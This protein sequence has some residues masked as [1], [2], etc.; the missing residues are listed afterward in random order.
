MSKPFKKDGHTH[1]EYC[2]HG[3][4]QDVEELIQKAIQ[5]DFSDYSITEHAPLP[6]EI[7]TTQAAGNPE[8]WTTAAMA[9]N[10]VEHYFK[11]MQLLKK[12]Y[13]SDIQLHIG[14]ELDYFD[15]AQDWTTDFLNEYGPLTDDGVLSVHFLP[16]NGGLWGIDYSFE[17]Y[18]RGVVDSLGSFQAAQ[19]LYYQKVLAS[20]QADLGPYKP[21]RLGH[22][23]LCQK[24][25]ALFPE[26]TNLSLE[27][28]QLIQELYLNIMQQ[29]Y[30][31][32]LNTA[33][34]DKAAYG[35]SYPGPGLIKQ[36]LA[37]RIP[38]VYGSDAHSF[39]EVGRYYDKVAEVLM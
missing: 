12:K 20:L 15:A 1:T 3:N 28:L 39:Q 5:L 25:E 26:E 23:T 16:G 4:V 21:K 37:L 36:A 18:K 30:E 32:D 38:L 22:I 8:V 6:P 11:K 10:D 34:F 9:L 2:P 27:S 13:A 24:F 14:F 7:M 29:G 17:E 33:G 31:L 35:K 19:E